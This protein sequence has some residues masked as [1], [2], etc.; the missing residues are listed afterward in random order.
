[1]TIS[2]MESF[3]QQ[4]GGSFG[5]EHDI[6]FFLSG[7]Q[8]SSAFTFNR[9]KHLGKFCEVNSI[10]LK[11]CSI[12]TGTKKSKSEENNYFMTSHLP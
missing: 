9:R 6:S 1:M 5:K 12:K 2:F 7:F 11:I 4:L 10:F 3:G 8:R